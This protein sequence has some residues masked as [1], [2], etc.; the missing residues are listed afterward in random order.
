MTVWIIEFI[1]TTHDAEKIIEW[2]ETLTRQFTKITEKCKLIE[3][4][5]RDCPEKA[6]TEWRLLSQKQ[7][8]RSMWKKKWRKTIEYEHEIGFLEGFLDSAAVRLG[9]AFILRREHW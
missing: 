4:N 8:T 1:T 9:W 6:K 2:T 7:V 3:G 5:C